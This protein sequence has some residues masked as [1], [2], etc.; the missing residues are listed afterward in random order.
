MVS[1]TTLWAFLSVYK[2]QASMAFKATQTSFSKPK[3]VSRISPETSVGWFV[4]F[5]RPRFSLNQHLNMH[6]SLSS[7]CY[8]GGLMGLGVMDNEQSQVVI[9]RYL[10]SLQEVSTS[11]PRGP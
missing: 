10:S 3:C 2:Q 7:F 1:A 11:D 9:C 4:D 5:C 6:V 8:L